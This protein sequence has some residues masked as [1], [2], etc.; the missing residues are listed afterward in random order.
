MNKPAKSFLQNCFAEWYTE[1]VTRQLDGE[2]MD[3]LESS[4]IE[5]NDLSMQVIKHISAEWLVNMAEYISRNPQFVVHGFLKSGITGT[6]DGVMEDLA[7]GDNPDLIEGDDPEDAESEGE[8]DFESD[9]DE[10]D[11]STT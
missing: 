1:Q 10:D 5:P 3:E 9:D 4:E 7:E 8:F 6:L 11:D 2:N